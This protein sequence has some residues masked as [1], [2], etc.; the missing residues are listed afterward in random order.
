MVQYNQIDM[1]K[2]LLQI[3]KE[4][5]WNDKNQGVLWITGIGSAVED[6]NLF[7]GYRKG[8]NETRTLE[9]APFHVFDKSDLFELECLLILVLFYELFV[10]LIFPNLETVIYINESWFIDVTC[11]NNNNYKKYRELFEGLGFKEIIKK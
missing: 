1:V 5:G 2:G 7:D 8:L 3:L 11:K 6:I 9:E 4:T 10:Y